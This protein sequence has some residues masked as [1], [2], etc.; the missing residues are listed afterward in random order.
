MDEVHPYSFHSAMYTPYFLLRRFGTGM[1]IVVLVKWPF[2]SC[3]FL[4]VFSV[5]NFM[6]L[7]VVRPFKT[8]K[9]NTIETFN[10]FCIYVCA[11]IYTIL[12]RAEGGY[13]FINLM[14]WSHVGVCCINIITNVLL[15]IY[16]TM[17]VSFVVIK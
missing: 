5:I 2:F 1:I 16:N 11:H 14:G 3:T 12:C 10:E 9:V 4:M 8:K 13:E 17:V 7:F 15:M 6:Y